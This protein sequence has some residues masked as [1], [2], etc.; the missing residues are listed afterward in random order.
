MYREILTKAIIA[1][2]KRNI[3][4]SLT[5]NV[6]HNVSKVLGCWIINHSYEV[7]KDKQEVFIKGSYQV[8]LWFGYDN[9]TN[10]GLHT[11]SY[12][13]NDQIPYTFTLEKT[14]LN[15][16]NDVKCYNITDPSC[17]KMTYEDNNIFIDIVRDYE[18]DI[19]GETKLKIKVD[20]V[21]IDQMINTNYMKDSKDNE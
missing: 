19:V 16:K 7:Y 17:I 1:K 10:S 12:D 21:A 3:K 11:F 13:F 5:C 15:E 2:G 14:N 6:N 4:E 18:I 20:D 8:H 9:N